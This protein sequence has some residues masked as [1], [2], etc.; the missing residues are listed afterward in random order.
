MMLINFIEIT[1]RLYF[2][3]LRDFCIGTTTAY[4]E[5]HILRLEGMNQCYVLEIGVC[6]LFAYCT[7]NRPTILHVHD[8]LA[9]Q[10]EVCKTSDYVDDVK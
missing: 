1:I 4:V 8:K 10:M 3:T 5:K 2:K 6:R 9:T 7:N